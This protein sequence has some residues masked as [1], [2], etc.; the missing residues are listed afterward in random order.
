MTSKLRPMSTMLKLKSDAKNNPKF[1]FLHVQ[2]R[3]ALH[4]YAFPRISYICIF[5]FNIYIKEV[6]GRYV[7]G[8]EL[9]LITSHIIYNNDIF[10]CTRT[11]TTLHWG[12]ICYP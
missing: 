11:T 8:K 3:Y 2:L 4:R 7:V 9:S 10:G 5:K 6:F 12:T 1:H